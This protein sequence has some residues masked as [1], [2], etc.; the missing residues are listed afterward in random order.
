MKYLLFFVL[1]IEAL[2]HHKEVII[3]SW[4]EQEHHR[5]GDKMIMTKYGRL[6]FCLTNNTFIMKV[7]S[8]IKPVNEQN[9]FHTRREEPFLLIF[10]VEALDDAHS[11][12]N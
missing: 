4:L 3:I 2:E 12:E 6:P 5:P 7:K 8:I 10:V 9:L 1:D 11:I